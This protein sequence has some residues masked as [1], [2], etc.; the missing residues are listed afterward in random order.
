ML[1]S[2]LKAQ[3]NRFGRRY[4]SDMTYL[5]ELVS[6]DLQA[7]LK[8]AFAIPFIEH[9]FG[10]PAQ[11]YFAAR[12]V[13]AHE[14]GCAGCVELILKI[15]EEAGVELATILPLIGG[16]EPGEV[17]GED[18]ELTAAFVRAVL[19]DSAEQLD[20]GHR[21]L[22]RFGQRGRIGLAAAIASEQV[23]TLIKRGSG[24]ATHC[25]RVPVIVRKGA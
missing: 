4:S 1:N 6:E 24:H 22:L 17:A 9:R 14:G 16:G 2:I 7:G 10:L 21:V 11:V 25:S 23:Y 13:T 20:F 12:L 5:E 18:L 8:L 15:A 19:A 3:I